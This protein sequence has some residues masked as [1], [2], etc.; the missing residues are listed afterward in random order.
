M[1]YVET[2]S[3]RFLSQCLRRVI[4]SWEGHEMRDKKL[5]KVESAMQE[6]VITSVSGDGFCSE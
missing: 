4:G 5:S 3:V 6:G 2:K 1:T